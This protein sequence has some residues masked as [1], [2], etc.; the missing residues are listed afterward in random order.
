[1]ETKGRRGSRAAEPPAIEPP[2]VEPPTVE[3]PIVEP[4]TIEP[5]ETPTLMAEPA[6][7]SSEIP[8]EAA[9]A[10]AY[11]LSDATASA[12]LDQ[13][14]ADEIEVPF[15]PPILAAAPRLAAPPHQTADF[16]G[17]AMAVFAETRTVLA[18]GVEALSAEVAGLA[19]RNIETA[20]RT[21]I[22]ML[23]AKTVADAIAVNAGFAR[24]SFGNWL[25][26]SAKLSELG[27]RL[28]TESA[29]AFAER[30][31]KGRTG[32]RRAGP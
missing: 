32:A 13:G 15:P 20:A 3:P 28:A 16:G 2:T 12:A 11:A 6:E 17:E 5:V 25:G 10:R 14:Q 18:D 19:R 9:A 7:H 31:A 23:A 1:M 4:P 22:E 29:R 27:L 24:A 30:L 26:S 21:A 8:L